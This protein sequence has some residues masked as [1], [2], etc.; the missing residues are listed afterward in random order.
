MTWSMLLRLGM[1]SLVLAACGASAPS[2]ASISSADP[3][4]TPP[5]TDDYGSAPGTAAAWTKAQEL[6]AVPSG[7]RDCG[8]EFPSI[9]F[10][11]T[12]APRLDRYDC[13]VAAAQAGE[14]A[15]YSSLGRDDRGG[16]AITLY[17]VLGPGRVRI[18]SQDVDWTG[19]PGPASETLCTGLRSSIGLDAP[20]CLT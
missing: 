2:I 19:A 14:P 12:F 13:V 16:V 8:Q 20:T 17:E 3:S 18:V 15:I 7:S 10:P 1:A 6:A 4:L 11:T 9:G 5:T